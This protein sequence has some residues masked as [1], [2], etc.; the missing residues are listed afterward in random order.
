[1][2]VRISNRSYRFSCPQ[3]EKAGK[4]NNA[5]NL[6]GYAI[7]CHTTQGNIFKSVSSA[8]ALFTC[9]VFILKIPKAMFTGI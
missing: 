8:K 6:P 2:T 5:E 7:L 1:M 4:Q 3:Q 9:D